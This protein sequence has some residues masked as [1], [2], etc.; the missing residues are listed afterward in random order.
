V[1]FNQFHDVLPG[2]AIETAYEDARDQLGEATAVAKRVLVRA[3]NVLARQVDVPFL[4]GSQ[5]VLVFNPHPWPVST[6][7]DLN[8]GVQ[9][10]GVRV[11]DEAGRTV[12]SQPTSPTST[13]NDP[14]R[15]AVVFRADL[16][17]LG[18]R[19]Y[20]LVAA[21]PVVAVP[22]WSAGLPQPLSVSGTVLEN[23]LVTVA[24]D[25]ETG[26]ISS[27]RDRRS[28]LDL[29]AGT[30]PATHTQVSADPTDTWGH[31][32][33]SYAWPGEAMAL[34]RIVVREAGPLRGRVRVEWTWGA[35]LLVE[36]LLLEHDS[37]VLRVEVT[38]DWHEP[39][40][41]L[42]LRFPTALAEARATFEVPFGHLGRPVDGAEQPAQSWV[43]LTGTLD[44]QP[45]GLT[46]VT[47]GKH[48]YDVSPGDGPEPGPSIGL[49]AVR[50]PVYA[51]HDPQPLDPDGIYRYQ[52]QG[53]QRFRYELVPHAG[54]WGA[55][56]PTR[57]A[58]LL[59][60][61]VRAMLE[62]SHP[63]ALPPVHS[64]ADDGAGAVLVTAVKGSEDPPA[65]GGAAPGG[66]DLIVRAVETAGR[67]TAARIHLPVVDR[68]LEEQF[69]PHQIRT[70]RVPADPSLPVVE[71]DLVEWPLVP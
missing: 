55:L 65:D 17:A 71:V 9:R 54:D 34:R 69:A 25:P 5:P 63:G 57:R 28:G 44:G 58:A 3:H 37:P 56:D 27:Y 33:V 53:E 50:S 12:L 66:A 10:L 39:G 60:G 14:S 43:D 59:G 23:S 7:V 35:S 62:A 51:W 4:E 2:S 67:A 31:R 11:V 47:A 61:A 8:Y 36:E 19:L 49:T 30:D 13:T 18:Y 1:L 70:F 48:G 42:K 46:L 40:H 38:L 6:D 21:L 24:I 45:A 16:P 20:R 26:W 68:V 22:A 41:L 15:G 32:V 52:D 64:F 29:L